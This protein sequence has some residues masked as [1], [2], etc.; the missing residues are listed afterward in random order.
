MN[1]DNLEKYILEN[2]E[3]FDDLTPDPS[4]WEKINE[5]SS[6]KAKKR[7]NYKSILYRVAAV[8]FIFFASYYFHDYMSRR[9]DQDVMVNTQYNNQY[10]HVLNK[11]EEAEVYYSAQISNKKTEIYKLV[12]N[13]PEIKTEIEQEFIH[14]DKLYKELKKDLKDNVDNEQVIEAMIQNYRIKLQI[15]EEMLTQIKKL[16]V[17]EKNETHEI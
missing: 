4:V 7:I 8:V 1:P 12:G 15:L 11:L 16:N 3:N 17:E 2:R 6:A 14:L 5:Q 9:S 10:R 13:S